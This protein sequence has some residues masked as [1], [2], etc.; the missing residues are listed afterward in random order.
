MNLLLIC[1]I[2]PELPIPNFGGEAARHLS[3]KQHPHLRSASCTAWNLLAYGL[4]RLGV[5]ALPEVRFEPGG[6]PYFPHEEL[7]FSL[8][9]SGQLAAALLS[10]A[11]CAVDLEA[12]RSELAQR[13]QARCLSP[14]ERRQN[15][16][17]FDCWTKKECIGKLRGAGITAHPASIDTL[18][19]EF[20]RCFFLHRIADSR[21]QEYAI[22]ALCMNEAPPRIEKIVPEK[23]KF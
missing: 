6:R 18:A 20:A 22:A 8:S 7:H 16:D 19:P 2:A 23:L 10:P 17:F 9:H 1:E 4:R 11:P 3:E 5:D 14:K 12:V 15:L 13:L 21:A